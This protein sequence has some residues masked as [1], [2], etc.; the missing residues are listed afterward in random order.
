ML[1]SILLSIMSTCVFASAFSQSLVAIGNE[2]K[3]FEK[4]NVNSYATTNTQGQDITLSAGMVFLQSD[5]NSGWTKIQYT[6]G[7]NAYL[8]NS[9]IAGTDSLKPLKNGSFTVKN[10]P[11]VT[12]SISGAGTPA[13]TLKTGDKVYTATVEG[14][15]ALF[16]DQY[17][18][19]AYS[20]V[21]LN[22]QPT[23]YSYDNNVTHFF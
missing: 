18:N 16:K 11:S 10:N 4:P 9:L 22:G 3:I 8:L 20:F 19:P 2:T 5:N 15:I 13:I 14:N 23:V 1:K 17:G 7:L 12:V 6:P 21:E